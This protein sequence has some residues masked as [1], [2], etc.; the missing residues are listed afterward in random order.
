MWVF[1]MGLTHR[2]TNVS[3]CL[4]C[5]K[6]KVTQ[7]LA[8]SVQILMDSSEVSSTS[9]VHGIHTLCAWKV[10]SSLTLSSP[11]WMA[12]N[13]A[14]SSWVTISKT[15]VFWEPRAWISRFAVGVRVDSSVSELIAHCGSRG[16]KEC[17]CVCVWRDEYI[18]VL[19]VNVYSWVCEGS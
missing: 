15:L 9:T 16:E 4:V 7:K 18:C 19:G 14:S 10:F 5:N 8:Q 2:K 11:F 1:F 6:C 17:V 12:S 13:T 3:E